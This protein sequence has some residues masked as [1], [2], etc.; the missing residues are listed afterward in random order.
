MS[1]ALAHACTHTFLTFADNGLKLQR[2]LSDSDTLWTPSLLH[3]W[4]QHGRLCAPST[5]SEDPSQTNLTANGRPLPSSSCTLCFKPE[6]KTSTVCTE[7][8][9][10]NTWAETKHLLS[11]KTEM[12]YVFYFLLIF[13]ENQEFT[14]T[15]QEGET[16]KQGEICLCM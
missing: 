14:E 12:I 5:I 4:V 16:N 11:L 13:L 1:D 2:V 7:Y 10:I 15:G 9:N 3:P 8:S 6:A